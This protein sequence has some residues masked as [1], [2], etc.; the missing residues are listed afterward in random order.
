MTAFWKD[1]YDL[2]QSFATVT[3]LVETRVYP[4]KLPADTKDFPAIVTNKIS[5]IPVYTQDGADSTHSEFYQVRTW[6]ETH[7]GT[8][9]L[10]DIIEGQLSGYRGGMGAG[11]RVLG[12]VFL[13]NRIDDT[14]P[15]TGLFSQI[16]DFQFCVN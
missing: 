1:L 11:E 2:F 6:D 14:E 5:K 8:N 13:L 15:E 9:T 3:A 10:A 7:E 16:M 12:A 4:V